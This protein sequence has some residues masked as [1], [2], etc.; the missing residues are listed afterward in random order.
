MMPVDETR[1]FEVL[2]R[3]DKSTA[4][5]NQNVVNTGCWM[6]QLGTQM[7]SWIDRIDARLDTLARRLE[8]LEPRTGPPQAAPKSKGGVT[9]KAAGS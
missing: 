2:R 5:V 3:I 6:Q 9:P 1:L 8:Q 4:T 7:G